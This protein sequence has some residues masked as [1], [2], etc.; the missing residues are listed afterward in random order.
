MDIFIRLA[1]N[2]RLHGIVEILNM[3]VRPSHL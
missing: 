2:E 1:P 3:H